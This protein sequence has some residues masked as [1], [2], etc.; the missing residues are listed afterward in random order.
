MIFKLK[1]GK[2]GVLTKK[3]EIL[4]QSSLLCTFI[5]EDAPYWTQEWLN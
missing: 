1:P 5:Y 2:N 3:E 4:Q